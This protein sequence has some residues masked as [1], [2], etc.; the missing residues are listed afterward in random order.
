MDDSGA[1]VLAQGEL[2]LGGHLGI[3]QEGQC[4]VL[5][6]V[7]GLGVAQ[8]LGDLLIVGAAQQK[9]HIAEGLLGQHRQGFG[10]DLEDGFAFK[11]A[12]RYIVA[13]QLV[14]LGVVFAQL[15][16]GRI[17]E[18]RIVCHKKSF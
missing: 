1:G 12:H 14:V 7:A 6:V 13:C 18:F 17:A 16:H 4:H 15:E 9:V 2:T 10:L 8:N 5:V 3:A 11:L